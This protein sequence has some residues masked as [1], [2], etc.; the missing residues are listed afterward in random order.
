[1]NPLGPGPRS[2]FEILQCRREHGIHRLLRDAEF[3]VRNEVAH[4]EMIDGNT[5]ARR[6]VRIA[7]FYRR[8]RTAPGRRRTD[9]RDDDDGHHQRPPP[10]AS[11]RRGRRIGCDRH[12]LHRRNGLLEPARLGVVVELFH[13]AVTEALDHL[14]ANTPVVGR[15]QFSGSMSFCDPAQT[16]AVRTQ[17]QQ[18]HGTSRTKR[19]PVDGSPA[20]D[21]EFTAPMSHAEIG[22]A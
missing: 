22:S 21:T 20:L 2:F 10:E 11:L 8:N 12:R 14:C 3:G 16:L 9:R 18:S 13:F 7:L 4:A 1:M 5:R 6:R 19:I 15:R 17:A